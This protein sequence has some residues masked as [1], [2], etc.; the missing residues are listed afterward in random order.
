M[1]KFVNI[2]FIVVFLATLLWSPV[3]I[4]ING[5]VPIFLLLAELDFYFCLRYFLN[6]GAAKGK[7]RSITNGV[8]IVISSLV[9]LLYITELI[10]CSGLG[11][12]CIYTAL[13][14]K[15]L[16]G[17]TL[18]YVLFRCV[19]WWIVDTIDKKQRES[20]PMWLLDEDV[21]LLGKV[22]NGKFYPD[23]DKCGFYAQTIDSTMYGRTLFGSLEEA[24]AVHGE[25]P[26]IDAE[27]YKDE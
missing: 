5:V 6:S 14:G 15:L 8:S 9:L 24:V 3:M 25:L 18:A 20:M 16:F 26:I 2:A 19:Y 27:T 10:I 17:W 7:F 12:Q 23:S 11:V 4:L 21:F 1:R 22:R 13:V